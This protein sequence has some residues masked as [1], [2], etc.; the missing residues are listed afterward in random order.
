MKE[1]SLI[2]W[3]KEWERQRIK[4]RLERKPLYLYQKMPFYKNKKKVGR[5]K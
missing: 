2:E 4:A 5:K 3:L 1:Q